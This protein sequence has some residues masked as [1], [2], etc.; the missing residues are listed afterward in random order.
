MK[1]TFIIS[2]SYSQ[3]QAVLINFNGIYHALE[4]EKGINNQPSK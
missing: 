2:K 3:N 1:F 4:A